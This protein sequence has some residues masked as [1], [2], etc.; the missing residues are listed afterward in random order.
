MIKLL[1]VLQ[2]KQL[3]YDLLAKTKLGKTITNISTTNKEIQS[4]EDLEVKSICNE[5]IRIWKETCKQTKK[6]KEEKKGAEK[7]AAFDKPIQK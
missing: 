5:L 4:N 6:E 2:K 1:K 7:T 3:T